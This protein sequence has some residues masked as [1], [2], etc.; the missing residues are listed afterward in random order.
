MVATGIILVAFLIYFSF[1]INLIIFRTHY[2]NFTS[3]KGH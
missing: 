1:I 3:S 2:S